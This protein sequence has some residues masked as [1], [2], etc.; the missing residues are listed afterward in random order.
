M[1]ASRYEIVVRGRLGAALV[2]WLDDLEVRLSG[3]DVTYLY[4]WF[5]DQAALHELLARL[6]DLGIEL[7]SLRRVPEPD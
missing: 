1:T 7:S 6:G 2:R 3:P 4:G 5:A